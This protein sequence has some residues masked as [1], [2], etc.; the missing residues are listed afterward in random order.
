[1]SHF[2]K[3]QGQITDFE[4]LETTIKNMGFEMHQNDM[5][6]YYYG[7]QKKEHVIKL[8]GRYDCAVEN[9]GEGVYKLSY[10]NYSGNV[11]NYIGKEG[12]VLLNK[13]FEEKLKS[14][15]K[16]MGYKIYGGNKNYKICNP[17]NLSQYLD[18]KIDDN[19]KISF[20]AKGFP[21]K[22]CTVFK[23]LESAMGVSV[24]YKDFSGSVLN[25]GVVEKM[26]IKY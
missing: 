8:P 21:G 25:S 19:G 24:D 22:E 13:Y 6:R 2:R 9:E 15:S 16:K 3:V 18:V 23:S 26:Q 12:K 14:E 20:Q 4:V 10:D 11:E 1:M 17:K 5:C 7:V